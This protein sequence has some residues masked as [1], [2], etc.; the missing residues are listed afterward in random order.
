MVPSSY[1]AFLTATA[2][3]AAALIGLL[4]VAVSVRD[5]TIFG[6]KATA[7]GEA[8]AITAFSGLV[9]SFVVALLG[10]IPGTNLGV[11]ATVMA[12]VSIVTIVRLHSRLHW[13]RSS[14]AL[15]IAV[16][17][18]L[19]QLGYGIAQL[20]NPHR[21][22]VESLAY[23]LFGTLIVSLQRAWTLLKGK[24]VVPPADEPSAAPEGG[25]A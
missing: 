18:Y 9:N 19:V 22:E 24:Q 8:L 14:L 4:F 6:A 3:A 12:V 21:Q 5:E 23:V 16:V 20:V 11:A 17:A 1:D 13:A 15:L 2:T 25:P 7:G 10:L